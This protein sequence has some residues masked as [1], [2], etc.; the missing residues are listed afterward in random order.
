VAGAAA[1]SACGPGASD[2]S[3]KADAGLNVDA[4]GCQTP[5]GQEE[6]WHASGAPAPGDGGFSSSP[7]DGMF[8]MNLG[9]GGPLMRIG[10]GGSPGPGMGDGGER[11]TDDTHPD[12]AGAARNLF[13]DQ[14]AQVIAEPDTAD[15]LTAPPPGSNGRACESCHPNTGWTVG[16]A[17]AAQQFG[18][19]MDFPAN[20]EVTSNDQLDPLFRSVDGATSPVADVS[21]P[22]ARSA[23]YTL[24]LRKGLIRVGLPIPDQAE[25]SLAAVDDP[26]HYASARELSLFRRPLPMMN[27]RFI[28]TLMWDGRQT[29]A[30]QTLL[31]DLL[32]QAQDA[33]VTHEQVK[34]TISDHTKQMIADRERIIY[35]AQ[36]SDRVAGPLDAD[37]ARGGPVELQR[38]LSYFGINAFPGPDP[39]GV[40]YTSKAFTLFEAWAGLSGDDA[41]TAARRAI[42]RGEALFNT[43]AF[44]IASVPGFNDVLGMDAVQG[45]CTTCHNAPNVG[46][47]SR[48]ML[49]NIGVSDASRRTPDLPLYTLKNTTTGETVQVT[50]PGRALVSGAWKDIGRFKV[51]ALRALAIRAPYFHNGSAVSV[52][53]AVQFTDDRF[54][55]GLT[56]SEKSDLVAFLNAL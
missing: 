53:E 48:G 27:I 41:Q 5:A 24:L 44:T 29:L 11:I 25:F 36:I 3:A 12:P 14:E 49:M 34:Q 35:L 47:N 45:T 4:G 39:R 20:D 33:M 8:M 55:I 46:N 43:R 1:A 7:G 56:D 22:A 28:T 38:Q 18:K 10:D 16:P 15:S 54:S 30:C 2:P 42:A 51:P 23:A 13:F 17:Y 40:P 21:T 31:G 9:D 50:D 6:G 37:G 19:N 52:A 26:Y 32:S